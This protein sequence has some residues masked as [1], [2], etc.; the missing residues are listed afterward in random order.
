MS[1]CFDLEN[2]YKPF[3]NAG[4]AAKQLFCSL[5]GAINTV[6]DTI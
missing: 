1:A 2:E 6:G 5:P 3:Y 4:Y